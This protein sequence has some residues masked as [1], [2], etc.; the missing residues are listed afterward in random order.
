MEIEHEAQGIE[1]AEAQDPVVESLPPEEA[2]ARI[3]ERVRTDSRELVRLTAVDSLPEL[4][5]EVDPESIQAVLAG[6]FDAEEYGDVRPIE[7][8]SGATFL[9]SET[10]MTSKYAEIL[11]RIEQNDPC[12]AIADTVRSDSKTYPRPTNV[13]LF[14]QRPFRMTADELD[15]VIP[16]TVETY[17]DIKLIQAS[18][19]AVYLYSDRYM[20]TALA[21]SHVQWLEVEQYENP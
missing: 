2:W 7:T 19:G 12:A 17:D 11:A 4:L 16:R 6:M 8:T 18:T 21:K 1:T 10:G 9:Y 3:A 14:K 15:I 5:P 20:K 13:S